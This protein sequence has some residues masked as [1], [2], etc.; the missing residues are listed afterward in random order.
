MVKKTKRATRHQPV[1]LFLKKNFTAILH[2]LQ[3][4]HSLDMTK[5]L[6]VC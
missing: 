3:Y 1:A 6:I 4:V 5:L 2:S